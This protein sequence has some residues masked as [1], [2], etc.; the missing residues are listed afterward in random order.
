MDGKH[1]KMPK[2]LIYLRYNFPNREGGQHLFV[3][4]TYPSVSISFK[5]M[6]LPTLK[7]QTANK[8]KK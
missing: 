6:N 3:I 4:F 8:E 7:R 5:N 2:M 1:I